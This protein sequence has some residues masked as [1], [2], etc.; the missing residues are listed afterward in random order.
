MEFLT[1][2]K[3][4]PETDK[5][6]IFDVPASKSVAA[7]ALILAALSRSAVRIRHGELCSDTEEML[8]CLHALG[9]K[10]EEKDGVLTV[11]GCGGSFPVRKADL[12][13]GSAGTVARFLPAVLAF[14]RGEYRLDA[15]E[16]MRRRPMNFL[17]ELERAGAKFEFSKKEYSFPFVMRSDGIANTRFRIDTDTSTQFASGIFLAAA[18]GR[19]ITV[20]LTGRRTD[21]EYLNMTL[22]LLNEFGYS[23][24]RTGDTVTVR[25]NADA[26]K[27]F[28]LETDVSG[29]C[30]FYALSR[31][32]R[33][34]V[35]VRNVR[36]NCLQGDVA[37]LK[38]LAA[39]GVEFR[40]M[41][42]G[43]FADATKI[44]SF[45][46]FTENF[47]NFS[48]QTL[49]AAALAPF[50]ATSTRIHGISH[51][52]KQECD[53][54]A[55]IE[56]NLTSLGVPVKTEADAVSIDPA[57]PH[58]GVIRTF[59]DHRVAMA[60]ALTALKTGK[61]AIDDPDCCRKTFQGYFRTLQKLI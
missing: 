41:R 44:K 36:M 25:V 50:A 45:A 33:M 17:K 20:E 48:D 39:R 21:S 61:I 55:A 47:K 1:L 8:T 2:P 3:F 4:I 26:P 7:R 56:A 16:Q 31:L 18:T 11:Y 59:G 60:F 57:V 34:K 53:R 15:S 38:L 28:I 6:Y 54:I 9:V 24:Q 37:F 14:S 43:L 32:M 30:Y 19:E 13:V 27:E 23:V 22:S 46:G 42:E 40:Q 12:Y 49:T 5:T 51:I 52:Q 29:A 58:E 10:T 35:L